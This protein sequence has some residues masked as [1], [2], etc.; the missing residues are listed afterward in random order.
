[1]VVLLLLGGPPQGADPGVRSDARLAPPHMRARAQGMIQELLI[2]IIP[3]AFITLGA[4]CAPSLHLC[5]QF[6][7][8]VT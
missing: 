3:Y 4:A 2:F 5:V 7:P 6:T 8:R 1:M